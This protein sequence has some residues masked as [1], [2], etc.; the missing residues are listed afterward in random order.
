MTFSASVEASFLVSGDVL[1]P[2]ET[3]VWLLC[4]ARP[5]V[6][7]AGLLHAYALHP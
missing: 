4:E 2:H 1:P 3:V 6:V 7:A 5:V